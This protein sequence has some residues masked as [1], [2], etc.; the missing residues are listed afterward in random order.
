MGVADLA[1]ILADMALH[2]SCVAF[3][4]TG[5]LSVLQDRRLPIFFDH[6]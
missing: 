6:G 1:L 2:Y 5:R 4:Q 3:L